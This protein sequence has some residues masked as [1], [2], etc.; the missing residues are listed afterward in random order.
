MTCP[1]Q[2][3]IDALY[4]RHVCRTLSVQPQTQNL[5]MWN[6]VE[7]LS[8]KYGKFYHENMVEVLYELVEY[9]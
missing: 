1:M 5:V 2:E 9:A 7:F 6:Y 8:L 3:A 4:A